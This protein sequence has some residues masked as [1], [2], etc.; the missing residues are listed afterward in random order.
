MILTKY[1]NGFWYVNNF[2]T[3]EF[4]F[5]NFLFPFFKTRSTSKLERANTRS[6]LNQPITA[7]RFL[8]SEWLFKSSSV[9]TLNKE[10]TS[11]SSN[12]PTKQN[13]I[14]NKKLDAKK[15]ENKIDYNGQL[16][17][18][19]TKQN[20]IV[21]NL[22]AEKKAKLFSIVK[23]DDCQLKG[24]EEY[25]EITDFDNDDEN[26]ACSKLPYRVENRALN[27]LLLKRKLVYPFF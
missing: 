21:K 9:F 25:I 22:V 20:T 8:T 23:N 10:G 17:V 15:K 5:K 13:S 4:Y 24:S 18:A 27:A 14:V 19:H 6:Q 11:N 3:S 7:E 1:E 26:H 16:K 2:Q 12:S